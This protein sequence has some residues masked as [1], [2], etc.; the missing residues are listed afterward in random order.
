MDELKT[1]D[2]PKPVEEQP[3]IEAGF[4]SQNVIN[5]SVT[6]AAA[7]DTEAQL[8]TEGGSNV[9]QEEVVRDSVDGADMHP[10]A[11]SSTNHLQQRQNVDHP[12]SGGA[13][14][15]ATK[16]SA[17]P[18]VMYILAGVV[19][20]ILGAVMIGTDVPDLN[21]RFGA[22]FYTESYQAT[23]SA[24]ELIK[25]GFGYLLLYLGIRDVLVG[26]SK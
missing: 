14:G 20:I 25:K 21:I 6:E 3:D 17:L 18:K 22:D 7:E 23:A 2:A 5:E 1:E 9:V 16:N 4:E 8:T 24:C 10:V 26:F 13:A 11:D 19:G 12:E 15:G